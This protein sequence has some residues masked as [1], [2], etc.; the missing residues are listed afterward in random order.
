VAGVRYIEYWITAWNA[1]TPHEGYG[2]A[3]NSVVVT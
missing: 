2:P 3:A 1:T